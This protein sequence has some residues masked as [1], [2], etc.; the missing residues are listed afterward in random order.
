MLS[1]AALAAAA[2]SMPVAAEELAET[3]AKFGARQSVLSPALSP[4]GDKLLYVQ[5]GT[6]SEETIY[7]VDLVNGGEPKPIITTNEA[8]ARLNECTW[9]TEERIVCQIFGFQETGGM[10]LGFTRL[11][12]LKDDGSDVTQLTP[13]TDW[14]AM[15][16]VQNGGDWL[17]LDI[18]G[19]EN[20]ILMT[21]QYVKE[22]S[23]NTRIF[24]DKEGLGVDWVDVT[25]GRFRNVEEPNRMA[26]G[27]IAD[28]HG[29]VRVM[30][31]RDSAASGY[32]GSD[33]RYLYRPKGTNKWEALSTVDQTGNVDQGFVPIAVDSAKDVVYGFDTVDGY[34]ALFSVALDGTGKR[35]QLMARG[36]VDVDGLIR[37]GRKNRVVGG[38][39]ATEKRYVEYFDAELDKFASGLSR[40]LPGQPLIS[41][42]DASE[43]ESMLLIAASSDTDPGTLYLLEK[44]T[45]QL[46]PLLPL[47][48]PLAE[49]EMGPVEPISFP[50]ADGTQIPGYLT[51]PPGSEGKNLPA[52]VLPHGGPG[53]RDEWGFDWLPQFFVARGYAV[54]QPNYRGSAGYGEAW[55]GR[56]GFQAW[57]TAIGDVNDAGRWLVAQGIADPDR[58][59]IVGW[60]YGGYAALQSQVLDPDLYKAVAAI[61]PVT[62]LDLLREENRRYTSYLAYDKFIG[63]GPHVAAG[64]P[65]RHTA[66]FKAPV[67]L[68]HGT[69]DMNVSDAHSKL[70]EDRLKGNGKQIDY[71]E[72]KGLD[73]GLHHS[74]ARGIML[75]RIG[76]FL[77][78]ALD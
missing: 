8:Q 10:L 60:S 19:E 17:A 40:A 67:L 2:F 52:I 71:L 78:G 72:F 11:M 49:R 63:N 23:N 53:A 56:N 45:R 47:R 48:D 1:F 5:P 50:A 58:L 4:S 41:I 64:S 73:H 59:A 14:R 15:G 76:E 6:S 36:D 34:R 24:N 22:R 29:K 70:M 3:A 62:D 28:E 69:M 18:E 30:A 9:A 25:N 74:Q 37:I 75:K 54:L 61:A 33:V 51:L 7:V 35:E 77:E 44:E 27:Y 21:R 42:V 31:A 26:A 68:V 20:K 66:K 13:P 57:E 43:D 55:Y 38:S 39:Y 46:S 65:A 32:D 12:A 16:I